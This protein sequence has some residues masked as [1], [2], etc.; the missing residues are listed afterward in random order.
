MMEWLNRSEDN[1]NTE[2]AAG[3]IIQYR[4]REPFTETIEKRCG[5]VLSIENNKVVVGYREDRGCEKTSMRE[6]L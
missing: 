1:N 5:H 2:L 6:S 4:S 3:D